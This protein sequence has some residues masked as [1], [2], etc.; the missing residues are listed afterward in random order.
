MKKGDLL[1]D[2]DD[3]ALQDQLKNQ[4]TVVDKAEGDKIQAE[5]QLQHHH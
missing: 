5:E 4:K 1:V 3:S 2:L